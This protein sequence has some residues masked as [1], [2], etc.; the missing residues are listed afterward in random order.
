MAANMKRITLGIIILLL[1]QILSGYLLAAKPYSPDSNGKKE[2]YTTTAIPPVGKNDGEGPY[3]ED[4][5]ETIIEESQKSSRSSELENDGFGGSWYDEF[6]NNKSIKDSANVSVDEGMVGIAENVII[7]G[8]NCSGLW[9]FNETSGET[10][11]DWTGNNNNGTV[12]GGAN[13][14]GGKFGGSLEFD[15]LDDRVDCG[16]SSNLDV[17]RN[18][19]FTVTA[20]INTT[21]STNQS[22]VT[23]GRF[24]GSTHGYAILIDER[25]PHKATVVVGDNATEVRIE[26]G[27]NVDDGKWH[28]IG[29]SRDTAAD[30]IILY[31]D[32][33]REGNITDN[34]TEN[35]SV[36]DSLQLGSSW[37]G[38]S[39]R[40]WFDGRIDEV[41]VWNRTLSSRE[42]EGQVN[43][44]RN[45]GH[46]SSTMLA[47]P[48]DMQWSYLS[49]EKT[50]PSDTY[51]NISVENEFNTT[52]IGYLSVTG[53]NIDLTGLNGMGIDKIRFQA[54]LSGNGQY[55]PR[56]MSWGVEWI[57]E[58]SWRDSFI[59]DE[60]IGESTNAVV[61]GNVEIDNLTLAASIMSSPIE[62]PE[63]YF[64]D[65]LR[66][67]CSVPDQNNINITVHD[68][69]TGDVLTTTTA[70]GG[71]ESIN[72]GDIHPADHGWIYLKAS[73]LSA[74]I[75]SPILNDWGVNWTPSGGIATPL[76]LE[77]FPTVINVTEDS[78]KDNLIDLREYF[79]DTY[80][81]RWPP[82]YAIESISDSMNITIV[83]NGSKLDLSGLVVNWTGTVEIILNCTNSFGRSILSSPINITVINIDDGPVW[84]RV[85]PALSLAEDNMH[86]TDFSLDDYLFDAEGDALELI[87]TL[88]DENISATVGNDTKITITP[89][90]DYNGKTSIDIYARQLNN[91]S[92]E[93][94][95]I[96]IPVTVVPVTRVTVCQMVLL[97]VLMVILMVLVRPWR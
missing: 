16:N 10:A 60:K 1:T 52:I 54:V 15:G 4:Q 79:F 76:P 27:T 65:T 28:H 24:G 69:I 51:V 47:L 6:L 72:I 46:I 74:G 31:V 7:P 48:N 92:M 3:D 22:I 30:Q 26:S 17:N 63:N 9:H 67:N 70:S 39:F 81:E 23:R 38:T 97:V 33:I 91:H 36:T 64:W 25:N 13:W 42:I 77:D 83:L 56:L 71:K 58:N 14:T 75:N 68:N 87:L 19:S 62:L 88:S 12:S 53:T 20:W 35:I 2:V 86:T 41:A 80:A 49:L 93:T 61:S 94:G 85:P 66:I 78:P 89:S 45:S 57:K 82:S 43:R 11:H 32:G 21:N 73:F 8:G 96:T 90:K 5:K 95:I 84:S 18:D 29:L 59:G 50:E 44:F 55:T 34:T 40:D 37:N